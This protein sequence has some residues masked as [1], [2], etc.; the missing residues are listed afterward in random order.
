[1]YSAAEVDKLIEKL[2]A[3]GKSKPE[4]V[5]ETAK[6]CVGWA[7]VFGAWGEYCTPANRRKR[8]SSAH[9]TIKTKCKN[10]E[11][12]KT[13]NDCKWYPD[14]QFTRIYDCRGFTDWCLKQVGVDLLGE[15]CTSQWNT[16]SNWESKGTINELPKDTLVCLFV[17]KGSKMEHTGLG[18]NSE[19]V[20]CSSGV[21]YHTPLN[22]KWTHW[23]IPK[24]LGESIPVDPDYRPTLRKGD[25]GEY[26]RMAQTLLFEK[27]YD[28]GKCGID[29]DFGSAT[30][31]AVKNFQKDN[32]LTA[33]GVI[34]D[35]TWSAL[36]SPTVLYTVTIPHLSKVSADT[37]V[38]KYPG[39][40]MTEERG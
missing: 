32:G 17:K 4:I 21:E 34:G 15:G 22:K 19:S 20:E 6:A 16:A 14:Q 37:L 1:M 31:K 12:N 39:S 24:G 10:F 11:G 33:D 7:Y 36:E 30:Q 35:A 25:K 2:K 18:L 38:S 26:V 13:C 9:P 8:Y 3:D 27:G 23:A 40:V 29:G 28:L 5:W